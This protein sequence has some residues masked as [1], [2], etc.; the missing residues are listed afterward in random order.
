MPRKRK[1]WLAALMSFYAPGLGQ[2]Y[3]GRLIRGIWL[4]AGFWA[5][6]TIVLAILVYGRL[7]IFNLILSAVIGI[8]YCLFV[9]IDAAG[10]AKHAGADY[11]LRPYNRWY[12]YIGVLVVI[13][14]TPDAY[15]ILKRVMH[16]SMIPG[17]GVYKAYKVPSS[18]MESA[19][20]IGDCLMADMTAYQF[21]KP[22]R[23]DIIIILSPID[24]VTQYVDRCVAIPGDVI[25]IRDKQVWINQRQIP[26]LATVIF[27]DDRITSREMGP[28]DNYGPFEVAADSYF[29]LGD[30]RDNSYDSRFWGTVPTGNILGKAMRIH[31]SADLSRIGKPIE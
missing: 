8:G 15:Q 3:C 22:E 12:I 11:V 16:L 5:C 24:N 27:S 7:G 10:L 30:N 17:L 9:I 31:W 2:V 21:K 14:F 25:E 18:S 28:R 1:P 4:F 13:L 6:V 29:I 20:M 26:V 19:L 23:G